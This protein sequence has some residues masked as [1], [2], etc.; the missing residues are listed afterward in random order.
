MNQRRSGGDEVINKVWAKVA[1][2]KNTTANKDDYIG[3][4][5]DKWFGKIEVSEKEKE[6]YFKSYRS[7]KLNR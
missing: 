3:I 5:E 1:S 4:Y 2:A 7:P 6:L